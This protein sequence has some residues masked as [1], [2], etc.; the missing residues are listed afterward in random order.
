M[1]D[2]QS[3]EIRQVL[4]ALFPNTPEAKVV[5]PVGSEEWERFVQEACD[6]LFAEE[7]PPSA[8]YEALERQLAADTV[9]IR[10]DAEGCFRV[11]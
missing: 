11:E 8:A 2:G 1:L 9:T 10:F 7:S 5:P 3:E 6:D 4:Q